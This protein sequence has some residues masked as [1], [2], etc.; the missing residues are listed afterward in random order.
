[1]PNCTM[2]RSPKTSLNNNIGSY[3]RTARERSGL[4]AA[5]LARLAGVGRT[6][7]NRIENDSTVPTVMTLCNIMSAL[8]NFE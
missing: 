6:T 8:A 5:E 4:S 1:M 7:L 2:T 3:I